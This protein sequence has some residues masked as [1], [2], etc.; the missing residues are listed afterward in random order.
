[1]S[2]T[3]LSIA[4]SEFF[5]P[6]QRAPSFLCCIKIKCKNYPILASVFIFVSNINIVLD[7]S[8]RSYYSTPIIYIFA[9]QNMTFSAKLLA[10]RRNSVRS[11]SINRG[12]ISFWLAFFPRGRRGDKSSRFAT[13][14][15][16]FRATP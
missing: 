2:K 8:R 6:R 3:F 11:D 7:F 9:K 15:A 10:Q 1:M 4:R 12:R 13:S 16:S 5:I 14:I